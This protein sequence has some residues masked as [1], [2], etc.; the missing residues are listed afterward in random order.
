[1][2]LAATVSFGG[3]LGPSVPPTITPNPNTRAAGTT[4]A[5][6]TTI[7]LDAVHAR[8]HADGG[9]PSITDVDAFAERGKAPTMPGPLVR[10]P[11]GTSVR[12]SVRNTFDRPITFFAPTSASSFDSVDVAPGATAE[13]SVRPERP[14]NYFYRATDA[15]AASKRLHMDGALAGAFI[16]DSVGAP[17]APR[18]RVLM[19]LMTP[20]SGIIRTMEAGAT[21]GTAKG[22]FAFTINGR[23]WPHTERIAA[24]A[25]DTLHWREINASWDVH[26]MH[27]HGFY[28]TVDQFDGALAARDGQTAP[29]GPVVTERLSNFSSMSMTWV[30]DRAGN[31]LFHCHF[32]LH[33]RAPGADPRMPGDHSMSDMVGLVVGI[34]VK[35]RAAEPLVAQAS[36]RRL[37]LVA[38]RDS[39][40]PDSAP[41]MRFVL[42]EHGTRAAAGPRMSPE[43]D[44]TRG[45]PV[46]ITV[47]NTLAEPTS[48]HWH[49]MEL[50]SY[51]DGVAGFSGTATHLAPVIAPGDS[52]TA[53][54]T[55]PR[56]GTFMYHSHH[57]DFRQ[58]PAGL[59]GPMIVRDAT[60]GP[61]EDDHDIFING[62]PAVISRGAPLAVNGKVDADTIVFR[63]GHAQRLRFMS[64]AL[65]NPNATV[66]LT[67]RPDSTVANP[68][69]STVVRWRP[70]AKDGADLP[71]SARAPVLARQLISMGETYD[72]EYTPERPGRLRIEIR[73]AGPAG[74]LLTRVPVVV[75]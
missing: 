12:F 74:A 49:G 1:L 66:W 30:P 28:F 70:I 73:G 13:I 11:V 7:E 55:P 8:W 54:F 9:T 36:V 10:V 6:I 47:V 26:P 42:D 64:L 46:A 23:S 3:V 31:W 22:K 45:E 48:V 43:L 16:V 15:S 4:R 56:A 60:T 62:T 58:Q 24:T 53:R 29:A 52:F 69:D 20:D 50:E 39:A 25:G 17:R 32:A 63:A 19:I 72:F 27:L 18:D 35:P 37:R 38:V 33:L 75:R 44:L 59:V 57:D 67:A 65:I 5:G 71:L 40:Y 41:S 61:R 68:G 34:E 14:G 51:D 21:L 2:V